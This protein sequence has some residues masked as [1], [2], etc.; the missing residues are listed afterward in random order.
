[1]VLV[2]KSC[3]SVL[4]A[5]ISSADRPKACRFPSKVFQAFCELFSSEAISRT[6]LVIVPIP[7]V[8]AELIR[9]APKTDLKTDP[10][11]EPAFSSPPNRALSLLT[12]D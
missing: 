2:A 7:V 6:P 12:P 5:L 4:A 11:F 1:M 8:R 3:I 9:L 10:T